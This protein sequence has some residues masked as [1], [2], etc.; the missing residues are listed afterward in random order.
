MAPS[1]P[2]TSAPSRSARLPGHPDLTSVSLR[3]PAGLLLRAAAPRLPF[4]F[5]GSLQNGY[6]SSNH[7]SRAHPHP[8]P[9]RADR[10]PQQGR[11]FQRGIFWQIPRARHRRH[12]CQGGAVWLVGSR[13]QDNKSEFQLC[14]QVDFASSL[15]GSDETQRTAILKIL[16]DVV[17]SKNAV[18]LNPTHTDAA[19]I[20]PPQGG[21]VNKTPTPSCTSR[22]IS[23]VR[24]SASSRSGCSPTSR[25]EFPGVRHLPQHPHPLRRAAP[26]V[27]PPQQSGPRDPAPPASPAL[28]HGPRRLPRLP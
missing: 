13:A 2:R 15:F 24:P 25:Q 19:D 6:R 8:A 9:G 20:A 3:P 11:D 16:T 7:R 4:R 28:H 12:R 14:A 10:R 5:P 26:P 1:S 22:C 27:P 21:S 23:T 18:I 17:R